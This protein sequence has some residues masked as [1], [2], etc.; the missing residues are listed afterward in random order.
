M[1]TFYS[2]FFSSGLLANEGPQQVLPRT[3]SPST[4]RA[5]LAS[6]PPIDTTP[7]GPTA[8][9]PSTQATH[10]ASSTLPTIS[11]APSDSAQPRLRRRRSSLAGANSPLAPLKSS[12]P[13]R[14]ATAS[15]QRSLRARSGSDASVMSTSSFTLTGFE[16]VPAA[17]ASKPMGIVGR[18]RSGSVGTALR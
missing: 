18:L 3:G 6:L 4:P 1:A 10:E 5:T 16:P 7:T 17:P 14:N 8:S 12:G 13:V 15:V 9:A 11:V 2:S